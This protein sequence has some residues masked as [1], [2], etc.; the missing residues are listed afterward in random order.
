[1]RIARTLLAALT[2]AAM[3]HLA[4]AQKTAEELVGKFQDVGVYPIW[5]VGSRHQNYGR[6]GQ[7]IEF[8]FSIG[9]T[10]RTLSRYKRKRRCNT[11]NDK[12]TAL[13][14][15]N[16]GLDTLATVIELIR[17]FEKLD[18]RSDS[19]TKLR[20]TQARLEKLKARRCDPRWDVDTSFVL[21]TTARRASLDALDSVWTVKIE[22]LQVTLVQYELAVA[23]Q[24]TRLRRFDSADNWKLGGSVQEFPVLSFYATFLPNAKYLS[25]Y[26]G[27]RYTSA[28]LKNVRITQED[29][30]AK[31]DASTN[32]GGLVGGVVAD[33]Q[34]FNFFSEMGY[35]Y[36]RFNTRSWSAPANLKPIAGTFPRHLNLEGFRWSI[37]VQISLGGDDKK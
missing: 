1:M 13:E 33:W 37:G 28:D 8:S 4:R 22:D 30:V 17:A 21:A 24:T 25:P 11:I 34:S 36:L 19:L 7:G 26:L 12:L 23:T 27:V 5:P 10:K 20:G 9:D 29:S 3:P 6:E 18:A 32:G 2:F 31:V 15:F 14:K 16:P 35:N